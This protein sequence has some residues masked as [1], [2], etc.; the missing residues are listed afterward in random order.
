MRAC[1]VP[2]DGGGLHGLM[3]NLLVPA[4]DS[5]ALIGDAAF[6]VLAALI[7]QKSDTE[8]IGGVLLA[9]AWMLAVVHFKPCIVLL[10]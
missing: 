4:D 1:Y 2:L 9:G 5:I 8:G 6:P 7:H 10:R 3:S